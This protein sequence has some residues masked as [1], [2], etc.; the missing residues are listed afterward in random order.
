MQQVDAVLVVVDSPSMQDPEPIS[1]PRG[2]VVCANGSA[3]QMALLERADL[4]ISHVGGG[5]VREAAW[6]A[7]P[8][9]GLPQTVEQDML[10]ARLIEQGV[11]LRLDDAA[12]GAVIA[13]TVKQMLADDGIR[14]R[15]RALQTRQKT[16]SSYVPAVKAI[17]QT[18]AL[19]A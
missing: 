18:I 4:F 13:L 2:T 8:M 5:A 3:P 10:C 12:D 16:E 11:A 9:L 7:T 17:T 6:C 19:S 1:W 14:Q 15:A